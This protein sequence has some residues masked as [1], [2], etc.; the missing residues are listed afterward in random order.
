MHSE[1]SFPAVLSALA[2]LCLA[3][4]CSQ[5]PHARSVVAAWGISPDPRSPGAQPFRCPDQGIQHV[6]SFPSRARPGPRAIVRTSPSRTN[7]R[8][9]TPEVGPTPGGLRSARIAGR[10]PFATRAWSRSSLIQAGLDP[11]GRRILEIGPGPDL[12]TNTPRPAPASVQALFRNLVVL[13]EQPG[14]LPVD[15]SRLTLDRPG[16]AAASGGPH[17]LGPGDD[18]RPRRCQ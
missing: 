7:R 1:P 16:V 6:R 5:Q 4:G 15:P 3:L 18:R 9:R 11:R 2:A 17:L 13:S 8:L 12:G 10:L 14:T